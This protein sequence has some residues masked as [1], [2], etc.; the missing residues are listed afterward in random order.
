MVSSTPD[1]KNVIETDT[2]K[3]ETVL[4]FSSLIDSSAG[5][6][7]LGLTSAEYFIVDE[8]TSVIGA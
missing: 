7:R 6:K 4:C 8:N 3:G 2:I 1:I 5:G